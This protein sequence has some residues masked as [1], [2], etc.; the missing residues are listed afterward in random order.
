[1]NLLQNHILMAQH[2]LCASE[3]PDLDH[4]VRLEVCLTDRR[5]RCPFNALLAAA[6]RTTSALLSFF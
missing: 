6:E 2:W 5:W 4:P 3:A 1:M